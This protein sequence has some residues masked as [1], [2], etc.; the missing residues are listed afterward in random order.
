MLHWLL[1]PFTFLISLTGR[2]FA[3]ILGIVLLIVGGILTFTIVGA[4]VG[5]PIAIVGILLLIRGLF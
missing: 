5:I 3:I 2:L 4:A 1:W